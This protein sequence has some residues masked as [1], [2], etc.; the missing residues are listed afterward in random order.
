MVAPEMLPLRGFLEYPECHRMLT[1]SVSKGRHGK[2]FHYYHCTRGCKCRFKAAT[3]NEYFEK[4]LLNFQLA[5]GIR[6]LYKR[7]V[8]DIY[9]SEH[10][11]DLDERKKILGEIEC[12]ETMLSNARKQIAANEIEADDFKAIKAD[13]N[14]AL[15]LLEDR[16]ETC[17]ARVTV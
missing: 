11:G 8:L 7:V 15:K 5:P 6:E 12:Q 14:K 2:Y 1:G 4:E 17:Q 9:Q 16:L 3:V 10:R 13:C